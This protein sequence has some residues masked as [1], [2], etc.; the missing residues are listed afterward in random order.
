[1]RYRATINGKV[2]EAETRGYPSAFKDYQPAILI[3][4]HEWVWVAHA[5]YPLEQTH[6]TVGKVLESLGFEKVSE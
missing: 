3:G 1:M 2:V 5:N 6:H 4:G